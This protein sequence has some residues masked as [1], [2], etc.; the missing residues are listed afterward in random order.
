MSTYSERIVVANR[1]LQTYEPAIELYQGGRELRVRWDIRHSAK[2]R[3]D[4]DFPARLRH[5]GTWPMYGYHKFPTGGTGQQSVAQLIRYVRDLNRLPIDTWEYWASKTVQLCTD[6][7]VQILAASDY[8][9]PLKTCCVLC[10]TTDYS[11]RGLDWWGLDGLTGPC[12][13][14]GRCRKD[15][16]DDRQND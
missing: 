7:T 8:G 4:C 15:K 5:D 6:E 16:C 14:G 12:C 9:N 1:V 13:W 3:G 2:Q 11:L 10:G